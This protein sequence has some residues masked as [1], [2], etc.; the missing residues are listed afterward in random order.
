MAFC[1]QCGAPLEEGTKFCGACGAP[2][3]TA[4]KPK[5]EQNRTTFEGA[6]HKCPNCGAAL[7]SFMQNCPECGCEIRSADA[8]KDFEKKYSEASSNRKKVDLIRTF[9]IPNTKEDILEFAILASSNLD[10][11]SY[12][13]VNAAETGDC[14]QQE[15]TEAWMAKLEQAYHKA[16]IVMPDTPE[17]SQIE[18]LF[19]QKKSSLSKTKT[20]G[21]ILAFFGSHKWLIWVIAGTVFLLIFYLVFNLPKQSSFE[22]EIKI[23]EQYISEGRYDDA[24]TKLYT[25]DYDDF[26]T[27]KER[28][29]QLKARITELQNKDSGKI[30]IPIGNTFVSQK[31]T[32]VMQ[33][34]SG[35]G[36]TNISTE[37]IPD[38]IVG[39]LHDEGDVV[40]VSI[41]GS[42]QFTKGEYVD[43]NAM[44][45]IRY[46]TYPDG[47]STDP[48]SSNEPESSVII[49]EGQIKIPD[50]D[51]KDKNYNDVVLLFEKAG[52][53][54][55]TTE[56]VPDLIIAFLHDDGD[57]IEVSI[58]GNTEYAK[59]SYANPDA[60]IIIRYH[61]YPDEDSN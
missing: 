34:L 59:G 42:T 14:P 7:S 54:N 2:A 17:L 21:G 37:K 15:V 44:I 53:T 52:F 33:Q 11:S 39:F 36:F 20:K 1:K 16:S 18:K 13:R 46:H 40:E 29:D 25:I 48:V 50:V 4:Q 38:L 41:N 60:L 19:N 5:A 49:E 61:G 55:I 32:D 31:Y 56:K 30:P 58:D 24:L 51:V 22:N 23:V 35:A 27:Q 45:I 12:I 43:R 10:E 57:V 3:Q 9:V 26:G 47:S 8:L 6:V 28:V